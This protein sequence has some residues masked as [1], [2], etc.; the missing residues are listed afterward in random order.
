MDSMD[1]AYMLRVVKNTGLFVRNVYSRQ[2]FLLPLHLLCVA[3][4][5]SDA[6]HGANKH[7][8]IIIIIDTYES[9][10]NRFHFNSRFV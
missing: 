2:L 8:L 7:Y 6:V 5:L 1:I 10:R 9:I 4:R 3:M